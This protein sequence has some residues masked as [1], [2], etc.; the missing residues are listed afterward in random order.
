MWRGISIV[1][2]FSGVLCSC[3]GI[4]KEEAMRQVDQLI[5]LYEENRPKFV[6]QKSELEKA[7]SCDRATALRQAA[8]DK[9]RAASMSKESDDNL[10][11]VQMELLQAEKNCQAK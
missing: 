3:G 5:V 9:I 1:L 11:K 8:D 2:L 6:L 7:S 4:S 10:T